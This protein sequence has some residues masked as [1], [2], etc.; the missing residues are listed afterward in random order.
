MNTAAV[1]K[2]FLGGERSY[3][4]LFL[5]GFLL[6][7]LVMGCHLVSKTPSRD[8]YNYKF[9]SK[10]WKA[11]V[12]E[13]VA[14]PDRQD[15]IIESSRITGDGFTKLKIESEE[16]RRAYLRTLACY[17][18]DLNAF[19]PVLKRIEAAEETATHTILDLLD[20]VR[21]NTTQ[22]ELKLLIKRKL[23]P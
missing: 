10:E 9:M 16:I 12:R 5:C 11:L 22:E 21:E 1:K 2:W 15:N 14:D 17:E 7:I 18:C 23:E 3:A 4:R 6:L 8:L 13:I 20:A 19:E